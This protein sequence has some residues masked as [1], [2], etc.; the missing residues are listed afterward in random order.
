MLTAL[1][2]NYSGFPQGIQGPELMQNMRKQ[3]KR[4]GAEII[5]DDFT[6]GVFSTSPFKVRAGEKEYKGRSV[7][8]ATGAETKWL[9]VKGERELIGRGVSTCAPCDAPFFRNKN[10]IVVGGGDS[11]M[12]EAIVLTSFAK[13]VA[14]VHR[15][16]E[17]RAS[18]IMIERAKKN[19]KIKFILNSEVKEILGDQKV[20]GVKLF[21]NK[22]KETKEMPIDGVFVAIGHIP[23]S[24]LFGDIEKDESG[25]IRVYEHSKT[26]IEGV[27]VAGDIHDSHYQQAITAAGFGCMAALEAEKWLRNQ[28]TE[29]R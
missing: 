5:D 23:N 29:Y 14:V 28:M 12:E 7:I 10:V 16:E 25:Y 1:V 24:L 15:R 3:A 11:A 27:F 8:I 18:K 22:T 21:N 17:F 13:S 19:P 9:G 4:F 2:E 26:N 20:E 6:N